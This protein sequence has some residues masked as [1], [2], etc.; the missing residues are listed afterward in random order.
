MADVN[1]SAVRSPNRRINRPM[2]LRRVRQELLPGLNSI[3]DGERITR[4]WITIDKETEN[5][6]VAAKGPNNELG[7]CVS[8]KAIEDGL[9]TSMFPACVEKL[10]ECL[11]LERECDRTA[12]Q[13][14]YP[15]MNQKT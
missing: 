15:F 12:F 13:Q 14:A 4:A 6:I 2:V 1:E 3:V 10:K 9:Y 11:L 8:W 7:F 5:L